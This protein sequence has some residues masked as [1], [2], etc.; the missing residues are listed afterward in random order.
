VARSI[1]AEHQDQVAARVDHGHGRFEPTPL[2]FG[3]RGACHPLGVFEADRWLCLSRSVQSLPARRSRRSLD[4]KRVHK[5]PEGQGRPVRAMGLPSSRFARHGGTWRRSAS[6]RFRA[7]VTAVAVL[8]IGAFALLRA[9]AAT[10]DR[11]S[12]LSVSTAISES[13][14]AD[15]PVNAPTVPAPAVARS[16]T[17]VTPP[18]DT[19]TALPQAT[20]TPRPTEAPTPEPTEAPTL[21]PTEEPTPEP[22]EEPT[23]EPEVVPVRAPAPPAPRQPPATAYR[24]YTVQRGDILKQ[25]AARYGVSVASI[26]AINTIPNP[27]SLRIGQVLTIP[28][29]GS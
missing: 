23:A 4:C 9:R 1:D 24:T 20:S 3:N 25:I 29:A 19:A 11:V 14:P 13:A 6:G 28:P 12:P 10:T 27:D 15:T 16:A 2:A 5:Q 18:T 8:V 22:T 21:E 26:I 17:R 7:L